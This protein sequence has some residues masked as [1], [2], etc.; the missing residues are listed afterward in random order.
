MDSYRGKAKSQMYDSHCHLSPAI[1]WQT[2]EERVLPRLAKSELELH[3]VGT[4]HVDFPMIERLLATEG[5]KSATFSVGIHPWWSH[6]YASDEEV[7]NM[8][9]AGADASKIKDRHYRHVL[10]GTKQA[11][12]EEFQALM[13]VLPVPFSLSDW[14]RRMNMVLTAYPQANV[15]ELGLDKSFRVPT[16]GHLAVQD[17]DSRLT[18]YRVSVAHQL[19]VV[20]M[21]LD[22]A[23]RH[24]RWVS[25]HN[26][27]CA[28]K[29]VE[30]VKDY[31][32]VLWVL[33]SYSGSVDTCKQLVRGGNVWI[34]VS[35]V[36]NMGNV[37][38]LM[39]LAD[40]FP[41]RVLVETDLGI[42]RMTEEDHISELQNVI[43]LLTGHANL[44][45]NWES[46][47]MRYKQQV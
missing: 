5:L 34:G 12:E 24:R 27:N 9:E 2:L 39:E 7:E 3:I 47:V 40:T 22:L 38:R 35:H 32:S 36:I 13:K 31:P 17:A 19:C 18:S 30:L 46:F 10:E 43:S 6:L 14:E 25:V 33:H 29:L 41:Q 37:K 42:D 44:Q 11:S 8:I 23:Q 20:R 45:A 28:G 21:Q 4:N 15:G 1:T 26:V 16:C